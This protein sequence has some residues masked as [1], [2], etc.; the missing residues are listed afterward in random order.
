VNATDGI[1]RWKRCILYNFELIVRGTM[2]Y[3]APIGG[4]ERA[5]GIEWRGTVDP[6]RNRVWSHEEDDWIG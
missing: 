1:E 6:L 2:K 4:R 5:V 3:R